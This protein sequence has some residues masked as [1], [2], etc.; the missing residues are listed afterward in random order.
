MRTVQGEIRRI[1]NMPD[2]ELYSFAKEI[3]APIDLVRQV[4]REGRLPVVNFAA[5]GIATPADAALMMRLGADGVF[6]GSGIFKSE[7]PA[8]VAKAIV[9]A[10]THYMDANVI[11]EVSTGLGKAM[12][13]ISVSSLPE[14]ELLV[15]VTLPI[16][17]VARIAHAH[18]ALVHCDAV[19]AAGKI[20]I[21]WAA[22]GVDTLAL[23][24]HKLGGPQGVGALIVSES[25]TLRPVAVGGGQERGRRAG[26]EN[27]AGIVGFGVAAALA[28]KEMDRQVDIERLRDDME[29]R[30]RRS[31]PGL[32]VFGTASP[33]LGNT[34]CLAMPGVSAETQVMALDLAGIAVSAG[35]AC[36]SG[37]VKV[38][39]V[40]R[41]MGVDEGMAG[42]A[43]RVSLGWRS[44]AA[45][46]DRFVEA[47]TS[48]WVRLGAGRAERNAPAA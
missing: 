8:L 48:L 46:I 4:K 20:A 41:A 25:L 15:T 17:A 24:A 33:R 27:V 23:S 39:H 12:P 29:S 45:D 14:K 32:T 9:E 2:D 5:G 11:A 47:F 37:K 16:A 30:L 10:T 43:I 44:T 19:Q 35:A 40:L 42:N 34:S 6:V 36:S 1:Q 26:T 31:V 13:G 18:G 3:Q 38:S 28:S 21:D 7:N 22:L